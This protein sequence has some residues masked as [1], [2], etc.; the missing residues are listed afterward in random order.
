MTAAAP[1]PRPAYA[2]YCLGVICF[3]YLFGFMDR[4]IV[5]LLT[6]AIQQDI[7]LSDSEMGIIQ[8]LAFAVFYT[9]FG[10]PIGL[11]ADRVNRKWLLTGGTALWSFMTAAAGLARGF[12]GLFATRAGVGVGEATLNPCTTSLIGDYFRPEQRPRAFGIYTMSTAL[13]TAVTYLG[14]GAILAFVGIGTG[15]STFDMPFLGPIQ[16]WQ[17][18]FIIIGLAGLAPAVLMAV[19]VRE[20]Q[21]R[22]LAGGTARRASWAETR[23]FFRQNLRTLLCHNFGV[24]FIVAPIYGL[25]NWLPTYFVRIHEVPVPTFSVW[26][27]LG[28]GL[29]GTASAISVGYVTG[30]LKN[31]GYADATYRTMLI[32]AI[33]ISIGNG[34][35]PLLPT[36]V[37]AMAGYVIAGI[38]VNYTPSQALA[39]IAEIT[40]NQL[41]GFVTS[42]YILIVGIAG[43][44]LGPWAFGL[45]T[46]HV[47]EDP[48][49][50]HYSMVL[51]TFVMGA[52]GIALIAYGLKSFR[53]S[54]SRVTWSA[55]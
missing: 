37:L 9:L 34:L 45:A 32:G 21:R 11:A 20:P 36:P 17:A 7:G 2:W 30:W 18:V 51:V 54:L 55:G 52:I 38:F 29:A 49:K 24:A 22:D 47:F 48:L 5:G 42:I 41:R 33:G 12:W 6:P 1:Y 4:I 50:I 13:G 44:G 28:G 3:A 19:T 39:A 23:T 31:K 27:G 14:G 8:G 40:P 16:G 25:V 15:G 53:G 26:Y 43:A 10:L 46:D 35:A